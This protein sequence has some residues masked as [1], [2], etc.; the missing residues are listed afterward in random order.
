M[1]LTPIGVVGGLRTP[2]LIRSPGPFIFGGAGAMP[3]A[4]RRPAARFDAPAPLRG[5]RA[6]FPPS[7]GPRA[8]SPG[9]L[10]VEPRDGPGRA[11]ETVFLDW[12]RQAR[13]QDI[14]P[15]PRRRD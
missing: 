11:A 2:S 5:G 3:P 4:T 7:G 12:L 10:V 1:G 13:E 15:E 6:G 14:G 9:R 8:P